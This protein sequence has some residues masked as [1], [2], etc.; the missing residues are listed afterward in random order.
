MAANPF[1]GGKH[2]TIIESVR[3]ENESLALGDI[4]RLDEALVGFHFTVAWNPN[5]G[6][7]TAHPSIRAMPIGGY[8][9][10]SLV[11]YFA[12]LDDDH[13]VLLSIRRA[14]APDEAEE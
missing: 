12:S 4:K 3:Y 2:R 5:C 14:S 10:P 1:T 11:I 9:V 8:G 13:V 7:Q 6:K